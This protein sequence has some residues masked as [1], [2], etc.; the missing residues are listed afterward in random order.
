MKTRL[1]RAIILVDDYDKAFEFYESNFFCKKI[2]DDIS[3]D[4]R[5][6]VHIAFSEDDDIGIWFLKTDLSKEEY[7]PGRQTAGLPTLVI[8]TDHIEALYEHVQN[9][10]VR[11]IERLYP[12][13]TS[14]YF[15]CLDLYG[16]KLTIL[17]AM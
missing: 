6:F 3:P 8:Y 17:K 10:G 12:D 16:N 7:T 1:G 13:S 11:I 4:G 15:H 5:R 14:P 2:H 9:N